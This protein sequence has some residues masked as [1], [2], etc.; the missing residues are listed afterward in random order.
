MTNAQADLQEKHTDFKEILEQKHASHDAIFK[1]ISSWN[2]PNQSF[3][4]NTLNE[5]L[6]ESDIFGNDLFK[7]FTDQ[8]LNGYEEDIK[9]YKV[10]FLF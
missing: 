10:V 1:E 5:C 2:L 6:A 8:L 4:E 3:E 9:N 7:E